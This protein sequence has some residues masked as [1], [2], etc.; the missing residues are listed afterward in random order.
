MPSTTFNKRS[1]LL[2]IK[3]TPIK[4]SYEDSLWVTIY[5]DASG[6]GGWAAWIRCSLPPY[7]LQI[8][9]THPHP[10]D[11]TAMEA[12]AILEAV[13]ATLQQWKNVDGLR[14]TTDSQ[15]AIISLKRKHNKN[16]ALR[17][18]QTEFLLLTSRKWVKF[19]WKKGHCQDDS[20]QTWLNNWCDKNSKIVNIE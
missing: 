13:K 12:C 4:T 11:S 9:G 17:K 20:I 8:M 15:S 5:T 16:K 1:F 14:I 2:Y 7:K 10:N 6:T 18:I 3:M 19:V